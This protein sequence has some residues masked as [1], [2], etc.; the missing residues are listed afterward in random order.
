MI[1]LTTQNVQIRQHRHDEMICCDGCG[2]LF[3]ISELTI[4]SD[5]INGLFYCQECLDR[6]YYQDNEV[7]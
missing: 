3:H 7:A 4:G 1:E 6:M 2:E 5:S